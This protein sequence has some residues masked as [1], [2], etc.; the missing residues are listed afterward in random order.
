[1]QDQETHEHQMLMQRVP[2]Y[3]TVSLDIARDVFVPH[4]PKSS[5]SAWFSYATLKQNAVDDAF[6]AFNT[7][8]S[9]DLFRLAMF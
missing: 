3:S 8:P 5:S 2:Q 1:M 6:H 7:W 9:L 4:L